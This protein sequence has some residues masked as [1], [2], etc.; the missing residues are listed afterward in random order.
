MD[1]LK[2]VLSYI[3]MFCYS[4]GIEEFYLHM[5]HFY[6][7][8]TSIVAVNDVRRDAFLQIN[9]RNIAQPFPSSREKAERCSDWQFNQ[10]SQT[11]VGFFYHFFEWKT[12]GATLNKHTFFNNSC[13][14]LVDT[15]LMS[16]SKMHLTK[17]LSGKRVKWRKR[18]TLFGYSNL[19]INK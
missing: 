7:F 1:Y 14:C 3:K 12:Q 13:K 16:L 11:N 4:A 8:F 19:E 6:L 5:V 15:S 17:Q 2:S 9:D 18:L 10:I